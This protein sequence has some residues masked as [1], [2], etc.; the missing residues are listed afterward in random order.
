MDLPFVTSLV[1]W[2]LWDMPLPGCCCVAVFP[3]TQ[4]QPYSCCFFSWR[5]NCKANK[6][7]PAS[8]GEPEQ[9]AGIAA[10][11]GRRQGVA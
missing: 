1:P 4:E 6:G 8:H 10:P 7:A 11:L 9:S 2:L 3:L 5:A